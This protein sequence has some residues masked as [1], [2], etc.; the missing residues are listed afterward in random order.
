VL[1]HLSIKYFRH[2]KLQYSLSDPNWHVYTYCVRYGVQITYHLKH[3]VQYVSV[4][5]HFNEPIFYF[6]LWQFVGK[7]AN[8][9]IP[10]NAERNIVGIPP[11]KRMQNS[12][13]NILVYFL[14]TH[15]IFII[16]SYIL[17][18]HRIIRAF[19]CKIQ[20][21]FNHLTGIGIGMRLIYIITFIC[22]QH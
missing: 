20:S 5:A 22:M 12:L 2:S 19:S 10:A 3:I 1:I 7:R 8:I 14:F 21:I 6:F 16:C 18:R 15:N 9:V 4:Y 13:C 11:N 17:S